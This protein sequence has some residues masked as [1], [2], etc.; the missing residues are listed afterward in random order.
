MRL[1]LH[2]TPPENAA[3][4]AALSEV[5]NIQTISRPYPDRPPSTRERIYIDAMPRERKESGR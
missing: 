5:L 2:A 3:M 4:L 1:R